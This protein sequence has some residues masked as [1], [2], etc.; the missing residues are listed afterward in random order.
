[1]FAGK[2]RGVS[3]R[4]EYLAASYS[5]FLSKPNELAMFIRGCYR[6]EVVVG[7]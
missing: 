1:M 5:P 2:L 3:R 4:A 7:S 6:L